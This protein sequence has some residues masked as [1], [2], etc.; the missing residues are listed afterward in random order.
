MKKES[1][2]DSSIMKLIRGQNA[3]GEIQDIL[4][5]PSQAQEEWIEKNCRKAWDDPTGY[6]PDLY[7]Q[8]SSGGQDEPEDLQMTYFKPRTDY[9]IM[10][11]NQ[12]K[13]SSKYV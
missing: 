4:W 10:V 7:E 3:F 13:R 2:S 12:T 9:Q 8:W 6:R 5:I 1:G 11:K